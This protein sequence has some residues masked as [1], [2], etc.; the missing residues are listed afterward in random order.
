M[1]REPLLK[2]WFR[3]DKGTCRKPERHVGKASLRGSGARLG[4]AGPHTTPLY[5]QGAPRLRRM[6]ARCLLHKEGS[7]PTSTPTPAALPGQQTGGDAGARAP[8]LWPC[9]L[10]DSHLPLL[11]LVVSTLCLGSCSLLSL[12]CPSLHLPVSGS[13]RSSA[14]QTLPLLRGPPPILAGDNARPTLSC[15]CPVSAPSG[16]EHFLPWSHPGPSLSHSPVTL[17]CVG[18]CLTGRAPRWA[19]KGLY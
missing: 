5:I 10:M 6:F 2:G 8:C 13:A 9:S 4:R 15:P 18:P 16:T 3:D 19:H 7:R 11:T 1:G 17:T 14:A 12:A